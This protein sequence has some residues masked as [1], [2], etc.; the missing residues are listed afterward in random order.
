MPKTSLKRLMDGNRRYV[1]NKS[2]H[3]NRS[4]ERRA[5]IKSSQ[6]PY[7]VILGCSDSRIVPE[8]IFDEGLGDL[9]VVRVA[10]NI[11]SDTELESIKYSAMNLNSSI[12]LVLGHQNCGAVSAVLKNNASGIPTIAELIE[13]SILK[14]KESGANN[15]LKESIKNNALNMAQILKNTPE[16][17]EL[18]LNKKI[19]VE[20]GYYNLKSGRVEIL[21]AKKIKT[22]LK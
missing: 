22:N 4:E 3:P 12:I 20:A 7:A 10:G 9:F 13:P 21:K 18:I 8:I 14:A 6:S 19:D 1:Y 15:L 17:Q 5:E 11:I 2:T 16:I